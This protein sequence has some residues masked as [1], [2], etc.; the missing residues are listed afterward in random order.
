MGMENLLKDILNQ[1]VETEN[2]EGQLNSEYFICPELEDV[3][4]TVKDYTFRSGTYT[5]KAGEEKIWSSLTLQYDVDSQE[6]REEMKRDEVVVYG[7]SIFLSI[8]A[9][10][11]KLDPDNNQSLA[12]TLKIFGLS[13]EDGMTVA[14][15]FESFK[16]GYCMGKVTHRAMENKDGPVLDEEGNQQYGAEVSAI[17]K[18]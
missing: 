2:E 11:L 8:D 16:G 12:R 14:E 17:G 13:I 1:T 18:A 7:S 10:T 15:I 6:A 9:E 5:S 3:P 4:V